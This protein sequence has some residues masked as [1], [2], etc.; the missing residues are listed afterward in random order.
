MG[1]IGDR[2]LKSHESQNL[3]NDP[4]FLIALPPLQSIVPAVA[5]ICREMAQGAIA[6]FRHKWAKS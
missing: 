2:V 3:P 4:E 5:G 6:P 1:R